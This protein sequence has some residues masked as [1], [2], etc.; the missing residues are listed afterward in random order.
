MIRIS[1]AVPP[2]TKNG[3]PEV[4]RTPTPKS[5][6]LPTVGLASPP[7][8]VV[9]LDLPQTLPTANRYNKANSNYCIISMKPMQKIYTAS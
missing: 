3:Q 6:G 9:E 4:P 2:L 8:H 5:V 7:V 1:A